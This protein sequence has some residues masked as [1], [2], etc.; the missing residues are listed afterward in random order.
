MRAVAAFLLLACAMG[1][2]SCADMPLAPRA[3]VHVEGQVLDRDGASVP[4]VAIRFTPLEPLPESSKKPPPPWVNPPVRTD[5]QGV[6]RV[7]LA[8]GDY[9]A[10]LYPPSNQG[11]PYLSVKPLTIS[12]ASSKPVIRF[13]GSYL[14][15]HVTGPD[16]NELT[17]VNAQAY[18]VYSGNNAYYAGPSPFRLLLPPATYRL[19]VSSG[20][21]IG[22]PTLDTTVVVSNQ[23]DSLAVALTGNLV[24]VHVTTN[25]STPLPGSFVQ[26]QVAGSYNYVTATTDLNGDARMYMRTGGY[27]IMVD[28]RIPGMISWGFLAVIQGDASLSYDLTPV[29]WS[30]T[31]RSRVD[32][33]PIPFADISMREISGT[34]ASGY[35]TSNFNGTFEA[36][37]RPGTP[38]EVAGFARGFSSFPTFVSLS[39]DSSF[40]LY[41][42][43]EPTATARPWSRTTERFGS[44]GAP[45]AP[46]A[47]PSGGAR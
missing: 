5:S 4:N 3:V 40:D 37:V 23:D 30:G 15:G 28:P 6:F 26:A 17:Y 14:Y 45:G 1:A 33:S 8:E 43:P 24:S 44:I 9:K 39:A 13:T 31:V 34:D 16:G 22:L 19:S 27:T 38:Y 46:Y 36:L 11:L 2:A 21:A 47:S 35:L 10:E 12:P 42:D 29:R 7:D 41:L 32:Q 20:Y 25:Q 18:N